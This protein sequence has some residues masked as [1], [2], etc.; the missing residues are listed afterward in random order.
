MRR[1]ASST[2]PAPRITFA[3]HAFSP[4][5][6]QHVPCLGFSRRLRGKKLDVSRGCAAAKE[7]AMASPLVA[8]WHPVGVMPKRPPKPAAREPLHKWI[9]SEK[10]EPPRAQGAEPDRV[11]VRYAEGSAPPS[12]ADGSRF[13]AAS[14]LCR[15]SLGVEP[16]KSPPVSVRCN[17]R[18]APSVTPLATMPSRDEIER[19]FHARQRMLWGPAIA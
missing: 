19:A 5:T 4:A 6:G 12:I 1:I 17:V 10:C 13:A 16:V 8:E 2:P 15:G 11:S 3:E 7:C 14:H 18:A 9:A